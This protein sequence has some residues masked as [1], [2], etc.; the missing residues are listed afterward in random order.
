MI[1][2]WNIIFAITICHSELPHAAHVDTYVTCKINYVKF[3]ATI[4]LGD[5]IEFH[6]V[7]FAWVPRI[8]N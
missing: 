3:N 6:I 2:Q 5:H 4:G 8:L 7:D 1:E